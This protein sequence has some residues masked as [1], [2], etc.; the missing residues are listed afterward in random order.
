M[1][2]EF[3]IYYLYH[4]YKNI[5]VLLWHY[6]VLKNIYIFLNYMYMVGS[7]CGHI[8]VSAGILRGQRH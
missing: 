5:E 3:A 6:V 4:L 2:G 1:A 7:L 8:H